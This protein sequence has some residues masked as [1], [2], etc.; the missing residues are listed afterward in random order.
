MISMTNENKKSFI[1]VE[2]RNIDNEIFNVRVGASGKIWI[3]V[4]ISELQDICSQMNF[5]LAD[6]TKTSNVYTE[7]IISAEN[8]FNKILTLANLKRDP[9]VAS[10]RLNKAN[11][12][13]QIIGTLVELENY[14]L[15][16]EFYKL[17]YDEISTKINAMN[18]TSKLYKTLIKI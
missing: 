17:S 14:E 4:L 18:K 9:R 10:E 7:K 13:N 8:L 5:K 6:I 11:R 2:L 3:N 15:V 12:K 16:K 1:L